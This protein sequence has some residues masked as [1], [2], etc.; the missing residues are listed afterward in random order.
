MMRTRLGWSG[1]VLALAAVLALGLAGCGG[2][3]Q[4]SG[5]GV[6]GASAG[7]GAGGGSG[8]GNALR[9][10]AWKLADVLPGN[11]DAVFLFFNDDGNLNLQTL[12][13]LVNGQSVGQGGQFQV[14]GMQLS[15]GVLLQ[16]QPSPP[17]GATIEVTAQNNSGATLR[18]NTI[19]VQAGP[20]AQGNTPAGGFRTLQ[21]QYGATGQGTSPRLSFAHSS[22]Q[23]AS[24][25]VVCFQIDPQQGAIQD[26]PVAVEVPAG[27]FSVIPGQGTPGIVFANDPLPLPGDF[28]WHAVVLDSSGWGVG[29][30]IDVAGWNQLPPNLPNPTQAQL[31]VINT[32]PY[33]TSN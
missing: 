7:A 2:A 16:I 1:S 20:F 31:Q 29:T 26:I 11:T 27:T 21:P 22:G 33:F 4:P 30:T 13:L 14:G 10:V 9:A 5:T 8:G 32:W 19:T 12:D 18:S 25:Q 15:K 23:A 24:Y 28:V 6:S 17:A 3:K